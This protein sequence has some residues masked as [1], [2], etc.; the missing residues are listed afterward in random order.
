MRRE[1]RRIRDVAEERIRQVDLWQFKD[2][3]AKNVAYGSQRML[4]IA[5]AL[6]S[7][8]EL[9]VLDEPSSGLNPNETHDLM[10]F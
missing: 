10:E 6:A 9:L 1:E 5:R 2:E 3:L 8:P 4:E 7:G